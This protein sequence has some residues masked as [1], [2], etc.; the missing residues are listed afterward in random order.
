MIGP[1]RA[2]DIRL[3]ALADPTPVDKALEFQQAISAASPPWEDQND[4]EALPKALQD[5]FDR[6]Y[7]N[8]RLRIK[9]INS[10]PESPVWYWV[11]TY[12]PETRRAS[13]EGP[14]K[15]NLR[16]VLSEREYRLYQPEWVP[17][18]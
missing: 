13:L 9:K 14:N 15:Q 12:D 4:P 18:A 3:S 7:P 6:R 2:K 16:P 11:K 17:A 5:L 8:M 1:I 10:D